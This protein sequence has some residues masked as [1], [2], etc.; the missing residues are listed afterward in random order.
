MSPYVA[1]RTPCFASAIAS[2]ISG[3]SVI[4]TGHPGPMMT[5][6]FSGN[7]ARKPNFA[8]ACSWLPHT[9]ITETSRPISSVTRARAAASDFARAGSRNSRGIDLTSHVRGHQVVAA[10][11]KQLFVHLEGERDVF[12]RDA[13]DGEPDVVQHVVAH[14][15]RLVDE[16][17]PHAPFDAPEVDHGAQFIQLHDLSRHA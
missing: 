7:A 12:R 1:M 6:S 11:A 17:E 16:I 8:I 15:H 3:K 4:Q 5:F 14:R 13:P 9:C 10:F 2:S